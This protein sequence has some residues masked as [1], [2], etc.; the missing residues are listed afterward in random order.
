[1]VDHRTDREC[2]LI[3]AAQRSFLA[4]DASLNVEQFLLGGVEQ[5]TPLARALVGEQRVPTGDEA[6]AGIVGR[7]DLGQIALVE[8]RKLNGAGLGKAAD[9]RCT[10]GRD[11]VETGRL[12]G[13]LDA[14]LGDHAAIAD[15]HTRS[16]LKR[17]LSLST[18]FGTV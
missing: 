18:W 1:M 3:L 11:E 5:R 6:L 8:E 15:Q 10:Q 13:L 17:C 2:D 9:R 14:S 7:G 16:S 4:P 12:D